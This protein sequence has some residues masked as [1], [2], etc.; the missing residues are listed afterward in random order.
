[1]RTLFH[2][3]TSPG[4]AAR[5]STQGA[6]APSK[7]RSTKKPPGSAPTSGLVSSCPAVARTTPSMGTKAVWKQKL[8]SSTSESTTCVESTLPSE[9]SEAPPP[10]PRLAR[11]R[12]LRCCDGSRT[13]RIC[14]GGTGAATF[15]KVSASS[16]AP[17]QMM[18]EQSP[19]ISASTSKATISAAPASPCGGAKAAP[20]RRASG[21]SRRFPEQCSTTTGVMAR[22]SSS[23]GQ[24]STTRR[25]RSVSAPGAQSP[26]VGLSLR[27]S[28]SP[29]YWP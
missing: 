12:R 13:L 6:P 2:P 8:T 18:S 20:T 7:V 27:P 9:S 16:A 25:R 15:S 14:E 28:T 29:R 26:P 19:L 11:G 21:P 4:A 17:S 5:S 1:M 3:A 22:V 24:E 23:G 10:P